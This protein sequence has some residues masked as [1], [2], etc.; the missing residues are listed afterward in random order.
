MQTAD[1]DF[2]QAYLAG[3]RDRAGRLS[4]RSRLSADHGSDVGCHRRGLAGRQ[5]AADRRQWRQRRGRPAYRRR[6]HL[7]ADVRP[8]ARWR[9][10]R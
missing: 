2:V 4:G 3:I 10:S 7:P 9:R 6:V 1:D 5:E 8:R